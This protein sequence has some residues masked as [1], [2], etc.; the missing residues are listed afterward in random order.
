MCPGLT[1]PLPRSAP[2][3]FSQPREACVRGLGWVGGPGQWEGRPMDRLGL[4]GGLEKSRQPIM[5][6]N[7]SRLALHR[8]MGFV[9]A[10]SVVQIDLDSIGL[11]VL[12]Y[13]IKLYT[14]LWLNS[15]L[16][17]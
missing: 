16:R 7:L 14:K 11:Y 12:L 4:G 10:I 8:A 1:M 15:C 9:S 5:D 6:P 13:E 17:L 2:V 3:T